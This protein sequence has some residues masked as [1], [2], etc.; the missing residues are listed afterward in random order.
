MTATTRHDEC[1]SGPTPLLMAMELGRYQWTLG[2]TTGLGQR[3]RRRLLRTEHFGRGSRM[4]SLPRSAASDC[5]Q[6]RR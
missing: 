6:T 3:P 4:N 5:P 1:N 2:F